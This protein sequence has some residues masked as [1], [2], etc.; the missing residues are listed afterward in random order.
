MSR[1]SL[2]LLVAGVALAGAGLSP[3]RA[4]AQTTPC[5]SPTSC[6]YGGSDQSVN[7]ADELQTLVDALNADGGANAQGLLSG[8]SVADGSFVWENALKPTDTQ[9]V[10]IP[11]D[12]PEPSDPGHGGNSAAAACPNQASLKFK[13]EKWNRRKILKDQKLIVQLWYVTVCSKADSNGHWYFTSVNTDSQAP[14]VYNGWNV[15]GARQT[16]SSG[17]SRHNY[18]ERSIRQTFEI[19]A[20]FT[21][22]NG[23]GASGCNTDTLV[24]DRRVTPKDSYRVNPDDSARHGVED[25]STGGRCA[26]CPVTGWIS[27]VGSAP[28]PDNGQPAPAP[29]GPEPP[30]PT[31]TPTPQPPRLLS[32]DFNGGADDLLWHGG[33]AGLF[34]AES[35]GSLFDLHNRMLGGFGNTDAVAN[36]DRYF[37]GDFDGDGFDDLLWHYGDAGLHVARSTP[38]GFKQANWMPGGFGS[39]DFLPN[40]SRYFVGDFNG[41]DRDDILWHG[42][43]DGVHVAVSTPGGFVQSNWLP[44][45]FGNGDVVANAARYKVGDFDGDGRDDLM[46]HGGADGVWVARSSGTGFQTAN[47]L[48]GGFGNGDVMPNAKRYFVGDFTGD[49][50]DDLLWHGGDAGVWIARSTGSGFAVANWLPGGFGSGDVLANASRYF[51]GDFSGD[52]KADLLWHGGDVGVYVAKSTGAGFTQANWLPGGFGSTDFLPNAARYNVGDF[53]GDGRADLSWNDSPN[54]LHVAVSN[55]SSLTQSQWM[56]GGLPNASLPSS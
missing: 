1:L 39:T 38:T 29:E 16:S 42:G 49:H 56:A 36:A 23:G 50:R 48:P 35:T 46:W 11:P 37:V 44:G 6:Q 54:S 43:A 26:N 55:G 33:D 45:G 5:Q 8:L 25:K 17:G 34:V 20:S 47:W 32:G 27:Q 18:Y 3:A 24:I 2:R 9:I 41:D 19:C 28:A 14:E 13:V 21:A 12:G 52:G 7:T 4:D 31:P 10:P 53:N 51:V 40:A 30:E 22:P 15:K